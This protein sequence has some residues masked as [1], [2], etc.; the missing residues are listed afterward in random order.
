MNALDLAELGPPPD[1]TVGQLRAVA[2]AEQL[3]GLLHQ[4]LSGLPVPALRCLAL[5]ADSWS[6]D[7]R[8]SKL[9]GD[10]CDE[11]GHSARW[12]EIAA[13][14]PDQLEEALK[15][16][17]WQLG[18][19]LERHWPASSP[20]SSSAACAPSGP[21]ERSG[22]ARDAV[23]AGPPVEGTCACLMALLRAAVSKTAP[24]ATS[25]ISTS[26]RSPRPS[27]L[28]RSRSW[29]PGSTSGRWSSAT[30]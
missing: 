19:D 30:A 29:W 20:R 12:M 6:P 3:A 2:A 27:R 15:S 7:K 17:L 1:V 13:A 9:D 14:S 11:I 10:E 18:P 5:P 25:R 21:P 26:T 23:P 22:P 8:R 28:S 4:E 24:P 16:A